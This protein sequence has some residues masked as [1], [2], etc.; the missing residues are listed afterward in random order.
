MLSLTIPREAA[1]HNEASPH[2][3]RQQQG[4]CP[5]TLADLEDRS[6]TSL[7]SRVVQI[8]DRQNELPSMTHATSRSTLHERLDDLEEHDGGQQKPTL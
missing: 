7:R 2:R 6:A 8:V 3:R 5:L 4:D 1:R